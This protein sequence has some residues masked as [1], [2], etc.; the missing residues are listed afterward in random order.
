MASREELQLLREARAGNAQSQC[1]LGKLYLFGS[2]S[3][4]QSLATALHWLSRAALQENTSAKLLIGNHIPY[5]MAKAYPDRHAI[6]NWYREALEH[7]NDQAG[8]ILAKLILSSGTTVDEKKRSEAIGILETIVDHD[9]PEAQ[10]LLAELVKNSPH[11]T[12]A[13]NN[14]LKWTARAAD[15]GVLEA[16]IALI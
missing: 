14:A 6:E 5:E 4:P 15:A 11:P 2:K 16:Q 7:G 3:L 1:E 9:I 10:W 12:P 13:K 8:L